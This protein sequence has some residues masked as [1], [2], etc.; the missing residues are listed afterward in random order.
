MY[1]W[2]Y[3]FLI[4]LLYGLTFKHVKYIKPLMLLQMVRII[5]T[6][7]DVRGWQDDTNNDLLRSTYVA[8]TLNAV[9]YV[10][11]FLMTYL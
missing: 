8:F 2:I 6:I 5:T 9:L 3:N 11:V 10:M 7:F 4:I 1:I